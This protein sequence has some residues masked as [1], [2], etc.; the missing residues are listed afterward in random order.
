M[1]VEENG[2]KVVKWKMEKEVVS[3]ERRV[4]GGL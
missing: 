2:A 1:I 3:M 4:G